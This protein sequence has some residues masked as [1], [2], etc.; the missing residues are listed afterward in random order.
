M[1]PAR[2]A[3][4]EGTGR[5]ALA[6]LGAAVRGPDTPADGDREVLRDPLAAHRSFYG[7]QGK[8]SREGFEI[9]TDKRLTDIGAHGA[10]GYYCLRRAIGPS[11]GQA[12]RVAML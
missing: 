11:G 6:F 5:R 8:D 10:T 1:C 3:R 2:R 4:G 9:R 12:F 7:G